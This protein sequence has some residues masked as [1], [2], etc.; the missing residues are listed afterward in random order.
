MNYNSQM[1]LTTLDYAYQE[2]EEDFVEL[3][4]SAGLDQVIAENPEKT[5][6]FISELKISLSDAFKSDE[7]FPQAPLFLQRILYRINRLKLFWYDG[8]KNYVNE[9]F[10]THRNLHYYL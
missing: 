6:N 1:N 5:A 7:G 3:L 9:D 2:L 8:L 10:L 4:G